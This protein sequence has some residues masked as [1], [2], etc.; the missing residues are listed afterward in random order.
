MA[1]LPPIRRQ[2][3]VPAPA[4]TAFRV[5]A[6][7]IGLWWPIDE[8]SVCGPGSG[9]AFRDGRLVER[10]PAGQEAIWGT[11]LD[12]DPPR[13]LRL[14]WHPGADPGRA[15]EVEVTFTPVTAAQTLVTL[16]HRGWDRLPEPAAARAEH[17][18][19]WPAVVGRYVAGVGR[20]DG[21]V[22]GDPAPGPVWLAL[23]HTVGPA[24][25]GDGSVFA[26][27]DFAEHLAFLSRMR[28]RGVLVAA[29]PLD[30][31][32]DGMT[33][34][35]VPDPAEVAEYVRLAQEDDQSVARGLLMVRLRPWRVALTG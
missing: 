1:D 25:D 21:A 31:A 24:L 8:L 7:E 27:P 2:V 30:G 17:E 14:T 34:L 22:A 33:V 4:P 10:G 20:A 32:G 26:H 5:F 6:D 29:G 12:W 15:G 9:V 18:R 16:E 3:V 11:V 23:M 19:G 28:E 13:R 35:R